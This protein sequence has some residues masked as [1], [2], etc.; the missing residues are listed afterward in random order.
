MYTT[1]RLEIVSVVYNVLSLCHS[2]YMRMEF[3]YLKIKCHDAVED[4]HRMS[5]LLSTTKWRRPTILFFSWDSCTNFIRVKCATSYYNQ[6]ICV[7]NFL[8]CFTSFL[9]TSFNWLQPFFFSSTT[10]FVFS[11]EHS[12]GTIK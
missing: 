12:H 6:K 7:E 4:V 1:V 3:V 8:L 2:H 9:C 10:I 11:V 5:W